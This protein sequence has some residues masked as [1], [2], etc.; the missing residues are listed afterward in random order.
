EIDLCAAPTAQFI[1]VGREV[2]NY[3]VDS[4][5]KSFTHV[6]HY[7]PR[8]FPRTLQAAIANHEV[9]FERFKD[10]ISVKDILAAAQATFCQANLRAVFGSNGSASSKGVNLRIPIAS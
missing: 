2:S 9:S 4:F 1:A 7:S 6:I 10:T 5:R 3:L 8:V